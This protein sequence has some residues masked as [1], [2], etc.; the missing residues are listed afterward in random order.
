MMATLESVLIRMEN[1]ILVVR[2]RSRHQFFIFHTESTENQSQFFKLVIA[3]AFL[4]THTK[5]R[6]IPTS[7]ITSHK[8]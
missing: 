2:A 7:L 6:S 8:L 1:Q 5:M 3:Y 4:K